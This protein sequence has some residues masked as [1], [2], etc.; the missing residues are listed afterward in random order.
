MANEDH[1][2]IPLPAVWLGGLGLLP[3]LLCSGGAIFTNGAL[4]AFSQSALI[5]Y[6]AVIL[7]FL[8]G[9]HW[10]LAIHEDQHAGDK[11]LRQLVMSVLPALVAWP[12][13]LLPPIAGCAVL[14]GAF[15]AMLI[16]DI[17]AS[18]S[19]AAPSWYP[20]LRWPLSVVAAVLLVVGGYF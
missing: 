11:T 6:G 3:F 8:G 14:A 5:G 15:I 10:G 1:R 4:K 16:I 13:L 2:K 17:E 18:K 19:G 20:R 7:S 12:C 9:I